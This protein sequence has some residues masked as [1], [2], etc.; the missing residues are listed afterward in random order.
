[1]TEPRYATRETLKAALDIAEVSRTNVQIDRALA[2]ASRAIDHDL[3][4]RV[5]Y[6][7]VAARTFDWPHQDWPT[8]R[9]L[10]LDEHDLI[11]VTS[12]VSGGTTID[13]AAVL[14]R[15]DHG[16]P[17]RM[18]ELSLAT[19]ASFGGGPT[20]QRDITVTGLWGYRDDTEPAGALT[21]ALDT[22]D[23]TVDVT[24][25]S[26]VGVG[27]LLR[28]DSERM[29]VTNR[30]L[31]D[32]GQTVGGTGLTASM[33]DRAL[34]VSDGTTFVEG[35]TLLT[36][37]ER[38]LV[39]EITGNTLVV[40]RAWDGSVLAAQPASTPIYAYRTLT[41]TRG[42]AGT[43]AATHTTG[44]PLT[45]WVPPALVTDLTVAEAMLRL[46]QERSGYVGGSGTS[47][48]G[49]QA[50]SDYGSAVPDLRAQVLSAHGRPAR[51]LAV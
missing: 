17:Y 12:V 18:V 23:T 26:T 14:L 31:A 19:D 39:E 36:G 5:F 27:D 13:P 21:G 43:T 28:V 33:A 4:R 32:T 6:P 42:A 29:V 47:G 3:C 41:V 24:A 35:E 22:T 11:S 34:T 2:S 15:P 1:M 7:R 40:R 44:T 9:R 51:H 49:R 37:V 8:S 50:R 46:L 20:W 10:W 45:R 25:S 48:E 16:P 38:L 30:R